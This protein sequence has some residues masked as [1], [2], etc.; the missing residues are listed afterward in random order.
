MGIKGLHKALSFCTV[1]DNL[2][3][4]RNAIIAVDTSSWMHK[5][6]YSISEEFVEMTD[7][8]RLDQ[9]CIHVSARYI[10]K[11]C[12]ELIECFGIR[13]VYL[14]L[15]GKRIPLKAD[16]SKDRDEK[17]RQ[18]LAEAR[19]LKR[20]GKRWK[21]ED[22]YKSCIR[23]KDGFTAAVVREVKRELSSYGRV[24]FVHSPH[25]ADSQLTRLVLDGVADAVITEDSDVL[26]YSAAAHVVFPVLFKLDRKTGNCD[27]IKMDWL[28]S[29]TSEEASKPVTSTNTLEVMFRR[30]A[31]RQ[32]KRKGFGVRLFVQGCILSGCDYRK[33]LE[34]VG[35]TNAFKLVRDN[36]FRN[37][38]VRFRKILESLPKKVKQKIDIDEYE[39]ILAKSEAI[40]FYHPVLHT[41]GKIKPLLEPRISLDETGEEHHYTDHYPFMSRFEDDWS[42]LGTTNNDT[43]SN[44]VVEQPSAIEKTTEN[45]KLPVLE[46]TKLPKASPWVQTKK[47]DSSQAISQKHSKIIQN[48]YK[49]T[50][51]C[52]K[53]VLPLQDRNINSFMSPAKKNVSKSQQ[54]SP[55]LAGPISKFLTKP[56]VRYAKRNFPP[57][58]KTGTMTKKRPLSVVGSTKKTPAQSFFLPRAT[59][60]SKSPPSTKFSESAWPKYD[61][62]LYETTDE[63]SFFYP[64]PDKLK[65]EENIIPAKDKETETMSFDDSSPQDFYDLTQS[66]SNHSDDVND[67]AANETIESNDA[68]AEK[69][70]APFAVPPNTGATDDTIED[71]SPRETAFY[72]DQSPETDRDE[73]MTTTSKYF[74]AKTTK[75]RRVTLDAVTSPLASESPSDDRTTSKNSQSSASDTIPTSEKE[76]QGR[77]RSSNNRNIKNRWMRDFLSG[78]TRVRVGCKKT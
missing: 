40:F 67:G 42:F 44:D 8:G 77:S 60:K 61:P 36:A 9:K 6:V 51:L 7:S 47:R 23:I 26:V 19:M 30:L 54:Q 49:K 64:S 48:P 20:Q 72:A 78:K 58:V 62:K 52:D 73:M 69:D 12:K 41:D 1:K 5:S 37:D 70:E 66:N 28:L 2:R 3:N 17:R 21:A 14:V 45:E 56:D 22:K 35:P 33:S 55:K 46:P 39:Q 18:N 63:K 59:K 16:E 38:A 68:V 31:A 57:T 25:E 34:G 11:R 43:E 53:K 10:I 27:C 13:A 4:Y 71:S 76:G 50:K 74:S 75:S 24:H 29:L 65:S 32:A 15:D